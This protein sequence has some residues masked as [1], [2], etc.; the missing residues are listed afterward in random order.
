MKSPDRKKMPVE[1]THPP[2]AKKFKVFFY[3]GA[4]ANKYPRLICSEEQDVFLVTR[5]F[6]KSKDFRDFQAGDP[7]VIEKLK[8]VYLT[9][10]DACP[11]STKDKHESQCMWS[12]VELVLNAKS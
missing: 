9:Y 8:D 12:E 5:S 6:F 3:I 2:H 7:L 10:R 11:C 1:N 4:E